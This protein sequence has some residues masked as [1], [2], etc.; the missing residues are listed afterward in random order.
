MNRSNAVPWIG[1]PTEMNLS[2]SRQFLDYGYSEA[3]AETGGMPV[4]IPLLE[5]TRYLQPVVESLDGILLTGS[6]SDVDPALYDAQQ[7]DACATPQPIRDRMDFFLLQTAIRCR[8]PVFAICYGFQ[9][10]NVFFGGS[11]IQDI[12]T[13]LDTPIRHNSSDDK[14]LPGHEIEI[15]PGSVLEQIAGGTE[16]IVNSYHHQAVERLG[17]NLKVIAR[18]PDGIVESVFH[19][20]QDHWILG[21]QWHPERSFTSDSF[22]RKLFENFLARCRAVRGIDEGTHS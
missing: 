8:I 19:T 12:P 17:Q 16:A 6:H 15:T 11:L 20:N 4:L 22:S 10:L 2:G 7:S 9:S 18:A 21:V 5:N 14:D 1:L 13:Q 3:I